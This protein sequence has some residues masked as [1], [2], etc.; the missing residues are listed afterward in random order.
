MNIR[1]LQREDKEP[2]EN[3]LRATDVFSEEEI[4]VAIELIQICLDDEH[5]KDYEIFSYVDGEQYVAG[6]VCIGPTPSTQGTFD[7]YWIAVS[8]GLHG[9]GVGSE[10]LRFTEEHIRAKGGRLLIAETSSTPKYE[11]TRAFYERKGFERRACIKDYYK[12][13]DDLIIY[14]KYL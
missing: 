13:G 9:K 14:G 11:K 2:I 5:Q 10:L 3:L 1:P 12:S 6:Y 8:P 7:L 4:D